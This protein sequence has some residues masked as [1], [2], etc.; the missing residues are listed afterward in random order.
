[1][2]RDAKIENLVSKSG[3]FIDLQ[4][5]S[6][7]AIPGIYLKISEF[8]G[9]NDGTNTKGS[10]TITKLFNIQHNK[11]EMLTTILSKPGDYTGIVFDADGGL[12]ILDDYGF[13]DVSGTDTQVVTYNI[14]HHTKP[15]VKKDDNDDESYPLAQN[16]YESKTYMKSFTDKT[17]IHTFTDYSTYY[18][19]SNEYDILLVWTDITETKPSIFKR[20]VKDDI[21]KQMDTTAPSQSS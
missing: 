11:V 2:T 7:T 6:S 15:I 17:I 21:L 12:S 8:D 13:A 18:Q 1:M 3:T 16:G 5:Y 9:I 10:T 19:F 20:Y 14:L 4:V